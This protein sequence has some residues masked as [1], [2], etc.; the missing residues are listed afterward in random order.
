MTGKE[1]PDSAIDAI[2]RH[3]NE[4]SNKE[5]YIPVIGNQDNLET[6]QVFE[7]IPFDQIDDSEIKFYAIDGSYNSQQ[8]YN[9]LSVGI[10]AGGYVCFHKGKQIRMNSLDDPV[11]LG[12]AYYPQHML[13]TNR[14]LKLVIFVSEKK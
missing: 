1:I 9:G 11:I 14:V 10:Y 13:I 12:K 8:F 7:I 3:I 6:P 4:K 2:A 5:F